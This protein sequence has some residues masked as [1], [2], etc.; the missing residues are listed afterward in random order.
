MNAQELYRAGRL[1]EAIA[2]LQGVLQADPTNA[3]SRTFLFELLCFAGELERADRQLDVLARAGGD[4]AAGALHYR[5]ALQAERTRRELCAPTALPPSSMSAAEVSG[6]FNGR[7][8]QRMVDAD[9]RLGARL[10]VFVAGQY[11]WLPLAHV[12]QVT[13]APP[14]RLRDLLWAPIM[15]EPAAELR[16]VDT[17]ELLMPVLTPFA[18]QHPDP[19]VRLGRSTDIESLPAGGEAPVGQKLWLIDDEEVPVLELRELVI[20]ERADRAS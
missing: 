13:M 9:P 2:A 4:V 20:H 5:A 10:E 18:W 16:H 17:R 19:L 3:R 7:P 6:T 1:D 8:F 11:T 15:V 12:A 14:Q